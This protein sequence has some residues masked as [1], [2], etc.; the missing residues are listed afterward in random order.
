VRVQ[1]LEE[2]APKLWA[3]LMDELPA[4]HL[5]APQ[6]KR[7]RIARKDFRAPPR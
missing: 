5:G 7:L 1:V 4:I 2:G 3:T 6:Y